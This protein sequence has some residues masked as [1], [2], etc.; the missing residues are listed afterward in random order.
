MVI[1][2]DR[3]T[4][5]IWLR[6]QD[7]WGHN[8]TH[9]KGMKRLITYITEVPQ[10]QGRRLGQVRRAG[11]GHYCSL[12]PGEYC[13]AQ[14]VLVR[15]ESPSCTKEGAFRHAFLYGKRKIEINELVCCSPQDIKKKKTNFTQSMLREGHNN[16]KSRIVSNTTQKHRENQWTKNWL[17]E[18]F[19]KTDKPL[20]R[21]NRKKKKEKNGSIRNTKGT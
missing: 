2:R 11:L 18:I 5:K 8:R 13:Y 14:A 4:P 15:Y 7:E 3:W 10:K 1:C 16:D 19:T 17:F 6:C 9:P 12:G 21:L 20:A